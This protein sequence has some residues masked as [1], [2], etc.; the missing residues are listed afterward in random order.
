M[1]REMR[2]RKQQVSQAE[3]EEMLKA[4]TSGVLAVTGD[5]GYPYAVPVSH[6]YAENKLFFHSAAA[7][8]KLDSIRKN[9]KVSFCVIAQDEVQ[10]ATLTTHYRS[11]VAFGTAR[12]LTEPAEIQHAMELLA[13]R[14]SADFMVEARKAIQDDWKRF[15][16]VEVKIEHLTGKIAS[17]LIKQNPA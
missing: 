1:F 3:A 10:P 17:E 13:A 12:V 4:A 2:R 9:P 11:A 15:T 7:G 14:F 8:H 16:A 5:D 6:V